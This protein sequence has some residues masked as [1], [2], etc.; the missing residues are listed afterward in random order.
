[1]R[2]LGAAVLAI[3]VVVSLAR[4]ALCAEA[5]PSPLLFYAS[6][7]GQLTLDNSDRRGSPFA[8]ELIELLAR[9]GLTLTALPAQ[10]SELTVRVER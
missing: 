7:S 1:M 8:T 9:P 4:L 3:M 5:F 2:S 6:Q 10:L